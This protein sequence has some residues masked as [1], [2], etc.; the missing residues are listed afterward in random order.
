MKDLVNILLLLL[1]LITRLVKFLIGIEDIKIFNI[2]KSTGGYYLC[3]GNDGWWCAAEN[4]S[5][6]GYWDP[7]IAGRV[8]T[9]YIWD[10]WNGPIRVR[11]YDPARDKSNARVLVKISANDTKNSQKQKA[12]PAANRVFEELD[13]LERQLYLGVQRV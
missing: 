8:G 1:W 4:G 13:E 6:Y 9:L 12:Y 5:S 10:G 3:P 2:S 7:D 11:V